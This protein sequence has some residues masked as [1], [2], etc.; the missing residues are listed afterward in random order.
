MAKET[1]KSIVV[2]NQ[3]SGYLMID[4][5]NK[6]CDIGYKCYL[7]TGRLVERETSLNKKVIVKKIIRYNRSSD[8][9][10]VFTW[11]IGSLQIL[12][13]I[14]FKFR[15]KNL[16]IVSNPPFAPI[17]P[18][19]RRNFSLFIFDLYPDAMIEFGILR[20]NSVIIKIWEKL[21]RIVYNK[22]E[23]ILTLTPSMSSAL[24]KYVTAGKIQ[25]VALWT[26]NEFL[27]PVAKGSNSFIERHSLENKFIILY[28]GNLGR[29]YNYE[30]IIDIASRTKDEKIMFVIISGGPEES[31]K[32]A[33]QVK[34]KNCLFLPLQEVEMLPYSLSSA[35]LAIVTLNKEATR[36]GIPSKFFN[37]L[38]VGA[39]VL[40]IADQDSD[41][42]RLVESY[43]A[44]RSF[45]PDQ[46]DEIMKFID[47]ISHDKQMRESYSRNSLSASGFHTVKNVE[48]IT[49]FYV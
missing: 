14:I 27:K 33:E 6:F 38:S 1:V 36:I 13:Y 4:I 44:G 7:V 31:R 11:V 37:F 29:A 41:L 18:F 32:R 42:A 43:K 45:N 3:D 9:G 8:S 5:L 48:D 46:I 15:K 19:F 47:E 22:A 17:L 12:L 10:R 24:E 40:C 20:E 2:I 26:N 25:E 39:P 30:L 34:L 28:S 21:N 16:L 49:G 35:D 23:R